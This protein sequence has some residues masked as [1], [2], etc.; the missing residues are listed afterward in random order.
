M[1]KYFYL[2][3]FVGSGTLLDP[4]RPLAA[5]FGPSSMLDLRPDERR[6]EGWCFACVERED[7]IIVETPA[8]LI[9]LGDDG[10]VNL[11]DATMNQIKERLRIDF[12]SQKLAEIAAE[13]LLFQR[14]PGRGLRPDLDGKY[15]LH[16]RG[17][18]W[19]ATE[20]EAYEFVGRLRE[21]ELLGPSPSSPSKQM[22]DLRPAL[23]DALTT[24][25]GIVDHGRPGWLNK[26]MEEVKK[27][28]SSHPIA[29]NYLEASKARKDSDFMRIH[30]SPAAIW[31]LMLARDLRVTNANALNKVT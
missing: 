1:P 21:D 12:K 4:F 18:L 22:I 19:E 10:H 13:I 26:E 8:G 25:A 6:P 9:Y 30:A 16:L 24:V 11:S 14:M 29:M 7:Q 27:K 17:L 15:R 28:R 31:I 23:D 5:S 20:A 2:S 3:R